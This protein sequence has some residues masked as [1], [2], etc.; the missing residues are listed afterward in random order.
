MARKK[1]S[2]TENEYFDIS[3]KILKLSDELAEDI[4]LT[5]ISDQLESKI[6]LFTDKI[7]YMKLFRNKYSNI[8][9]ENTFY[10]KNYIR[11]SL[12][13][14]TDLVNRLLNEKYGVKLGTDLDFYFPEDYLKDLEAM[15]EFFFIRHFENLVTYFNHQIE[16]RR[17]E[18]IERFE[19]SI[20][21]D[22]H[23]KDVFVLQAKKKF[24]NMD[25]I[26]IMHFINE[27]IDD[28]REYS[29]SAYVLFDTIINSDIEEEYNSML[30]GMLE[31]YGSQL[32][33]SGDK[34]SFNLYMSVLDDQEVR[35]EL[36]NEIIM[37]YL[38]DVEIEEKEF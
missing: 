6:D 20:Q 23:S 38:E 18:L 31:N 19:Q 12:I 13:K 28:V 5:N 34:E 14:V 1:D 27:I 8:N 25:D 16:A 11:S 37:R 32:V 21:E 35:N 24:K 17:E 33:F 9:P 7:N 30:A 4:I 22:V 10:D 3:D 15:Y 26:I 36:R 29:P 2:F